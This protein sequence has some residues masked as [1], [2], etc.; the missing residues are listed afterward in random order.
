[1]LPT[2][3]HNSTRHVHRWYYLRFFLLVL[4]TPETES[5]ELQLQLSLSYVEI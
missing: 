3:A 5:K 4:E 1:M 2:S